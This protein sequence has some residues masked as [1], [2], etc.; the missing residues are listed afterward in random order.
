MVGIETVKEEVSAVSELARIRV[1]MGL[2]RYGK[3]VDGADGVSDP[4]LFVD[5]FEAIMNGAMFLTEH[6]AAV[7]PGLM[8]A[9]PM[10]K[11]AN[12][13]IAKSKNWEEVVETFLKSQLSDRI[14]HDRHHAL[15]SFGKVSTVVFR[16]INL[17][18]KVVDAYASE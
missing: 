12:K 11:K 8:N 17:L 16:Y 9:S 6:W 14:K 2:P 3:R 18:N 15:F 1:P 4:Q 7:L 5:R 13:I 10:I